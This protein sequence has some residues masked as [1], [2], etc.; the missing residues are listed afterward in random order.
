MY[1][2][3]SLEPVARAALGEHV[4]RVKHDLGK[5]V[6]FQVR[7]LEPDA[8]FDLAR[9]AL[10]ADVLATRR[11]PEGVRDAFSLWTELRPALVGDLPLSTSHRVDLREE[12]GFV[13]VD[14]GMAVIGAL[15]GPLGEGAATEEQVRRGVAAALAVAE[16]CREL[17]RRVTRGG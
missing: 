8:P 9:D 1:R 5:Y 3:D 7:A 17:H 11:G 15:L 10:I 13:E 2:L 14:A 6:A 12:P 16:G 4:T